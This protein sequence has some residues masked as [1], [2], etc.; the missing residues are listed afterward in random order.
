MHECERHLA[1]QPRP[2]FNTEHSGDF[3]FVWQ[4][5]KQALDKPEPRRAA[6]GDQFQRRYIDGVGPDL[7]VANGPIASELKTGD[8]ELGDAHL[9][10]Y[11]W[12]ADISMTVA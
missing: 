2:D 3:G 1:F 9:I 12:P 7:T 11:V 4:R 10:Y 8:M 6:I 5:R